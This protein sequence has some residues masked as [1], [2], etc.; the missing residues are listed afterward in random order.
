[1]CIRDSRTS[2]LQSEVVPFVR[3]ACGT[4]IAPTLS[5]RRRNGG[6]SA[7]VAARALAGARDE[8]ARPRRDASRPAPSDS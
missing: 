1:M 3:C 8:Q 7:L 2:V 5:L 4:P 6:L